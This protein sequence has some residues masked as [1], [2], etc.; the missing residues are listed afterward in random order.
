VVRGR[1]RRLTPHTPRARMSRAMW[2]CPDFVDT[3]VKLPMLR[4]PTVARRPG[5]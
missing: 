1:L 2:T 3:W 4:D 5:G